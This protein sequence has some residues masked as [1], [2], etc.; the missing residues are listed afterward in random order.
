[1]TILWI[2]GQVAALSIGTSIVIE[3]GISTGLA[4]GFVISLLVDIRCNV[5]RDAEK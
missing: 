3:Y 4:V 5:R 1:M 2:A